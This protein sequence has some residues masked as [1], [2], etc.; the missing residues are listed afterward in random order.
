MSEKDIVGDQPDDSSKAVPTESLPIPVVDAEKEEIEDLLLRQPAPGTVVVQPSAAPRTP[1]WGLLAAIIA[2]VIL[3]LGFGVTV[4]TSQ[5][6]R[7]DTQATR[8][9]EMQHQVSEL[10][11]VLHVSQDTAKELF[12]QVQRLGEEPVTPDPDSLEV[13]DPLT[14]D[15]QPESAP[16][17]GERGEPGPPPSMAQIAAAVTNF[18]LENGL[19]KGP[20]GKTPTVDELRAMVSD[21]VAAFCANDACKGDPGNDGNDG[22]DGIDGKDGLD[23]LPGG[24]GPTGPPGPTCPEGYYLDEVWMVISEEETGLPS[25]QQAVICRP[26]PI[27]E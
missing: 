3:V 16:M 17:R 15:D 19:C 9:T 14:E 21:A 25:N 18:C 8:L 2:L 27:G 22:R 26:N 7:I 4:F 13:P 11:E 1:Q 23:G 5:Q 24:V 20:D 6:A 12:D 10:T